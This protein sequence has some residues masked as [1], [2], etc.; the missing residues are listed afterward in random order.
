MHKTDLEGLTPMVETEM[1][2]DF[3]IDRVLE[4]V[5]ST[6][7]LK[8]TNPLYRAIYNKTGISVSFSKY[9]RQVDENCRRM[10]IFV[11]RYV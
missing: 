8:L 7:K 11:N 4:Q 1:T 5:G 3:A 2:F 6:I 9:E 10:R